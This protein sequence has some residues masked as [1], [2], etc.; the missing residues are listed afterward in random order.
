LG[1]G[2]ITGVHVYNY[3]GI[4]EETPDFEVIPSGTFKTPSY[5]NNLYISDPFTEPEF[6]ILTGSGVVTG[7]NL[8]SG[9]SG[10]TGAPTVSVSGDGVYGSGL[11][12][13]ATGA[14]AEVTMAQGIVGIP[15]IGN[16]NKTFENTFNLFTGSGD[17]ESGIIYYDFSGNGAINAAK[18]KY[19]GDI[20]TFTGDQ[21][22]I[23]ITV[24]NNNYFDD[25]FIV[26]QLTLSGNGE[27]TGIT[28]TGVR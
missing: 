10:Y 28:I 21:S 20:V 24:S 18:T 11:A 12:K 6:S 5:N 14:V 3:G 4:Y 17:T 9:G 15:I 16:Y 27:S 2:F 1:S 22:V 13:I 25:S 7:F 19:S 26:A 8:T 23:D